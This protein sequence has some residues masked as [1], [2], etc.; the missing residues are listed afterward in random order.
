MP[1]YKKA[2][3]TLSLVALFAPVG[4]ALLIPSFAISGWAGFTMFASGT[5]LCV[6]FG[7]KIAGAIADFKVEHYKRHGFEGVTKSKTLKTLKKQRKEWRT[8]LMSATNR[9]E[10]ERC[11]K[12]LCGVEA[13]I[14]DIKGL[15]YEEPE[16]L[17]GR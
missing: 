2:L 17:R 9:G 14:A 1:T 15:P 4:L 7:C 11:L 12:G 8:A 5:A 6:L 10:R 3:L 16:E 13:R